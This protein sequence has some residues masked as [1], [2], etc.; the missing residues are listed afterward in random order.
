[1][2]ENKNWFTVTISRINEGL[3]EDPY[4]T[5]EGIRSVLAPMASFQFRATTVAASP[6]VLVCTTALR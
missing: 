2:T 3:N 5:M 1:M 6:P 4:K